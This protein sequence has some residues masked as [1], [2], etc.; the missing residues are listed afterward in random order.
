MYGG[1]PNTTYGQVVG[2]LAG[3]GGYQGYP[4]YGS[5]LVD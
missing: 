4:N 2:S 5:S 1:N 3:V